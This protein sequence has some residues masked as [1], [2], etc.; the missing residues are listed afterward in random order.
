M[1]EVYEFCARVLG[2]GV[3][4]E[5]AARHARASRTQ[6]RMTALATAAAACRARDRAAEGDE[7][8]PR[9]R[10][11]TAGLRLSEAIAGELADAS[12]RLPERQREALALRELLGLSHEQIA[13]VMGIE[14]AAVA[15]LLAR[16]RL[17]L[18]AELRDAAE[19]DA[20]CDERDRSLQALAQRQD[21]EPMPESETA[22]LLEHL[23]ACDACTTAHAAMLEAGVCY[24][25]WET[26]GHRSARAGTAPGGGGEPRLSAR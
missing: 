20:E 10:S 9:E 13:G 4:A 12:A 24:R 2:N 26:H 7:A 16:A 15:L 14:T 1:D 17:R 19:I 23:G 21:S 25:A 8:P 18:R 11:A 6:D 22:W 3:A 5:Q